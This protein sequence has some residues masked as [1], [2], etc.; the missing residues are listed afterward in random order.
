MPNICIAQVTVRGLKDNILEFERIL[1]GDYSYRLD[2]D[3]YKGSKYHFFRIFEVM[4][5]DP[6]TQS[7]GMIYVASWR[8]ECAWSV[9][10][11]MFSGDHT[12]YCDSK[13]TSPFVTINDNY[14]QKP[15]HH[16][17][18][19]EEVARKLDLDID[20]VSEE[21]GMCF[22][23]HYAFDRG[24]LTSQEEKEFNSYFFEPDEEDRPK[25]YEE[26]M[27]KFPNNYA[28]KE[29]IEYAIEN[30]WDGVFVEDYSGVYSYEPYD[31]FMNEPRSTKYGTRD[32]ISYKD[33]NKKRYFY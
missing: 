31:K 12:Y 30:N 19:I 15:G 26:F 14:L 16:A 9:W 32:M 23:E 6:L 4:E 1:R 3:E 27:K 10:T 2:A 18:C 13:H 29:D 11:C 5:V 22:S 8:I 21:P 33:P 28:L 17:V 24:T 20:I 7:N 25:T